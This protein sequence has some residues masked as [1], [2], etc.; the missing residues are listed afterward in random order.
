MVYESEETTEWSWLQHD[1]DDDD[2]IDVILTWGTGWGP[3]HRNV[4]VGV[5]SGLH[6]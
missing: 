6:M 5:V 2:G 3:G 4:C 1:D